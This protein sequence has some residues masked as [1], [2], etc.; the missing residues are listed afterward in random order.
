ME[1]CSVWK[2]FENTPFHGTVAVEIGCIIKS[3]VLAFF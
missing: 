2:L 1:V 3:K